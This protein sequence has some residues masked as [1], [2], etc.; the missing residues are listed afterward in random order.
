MT[1]SIIRFA[2]RFF[3]GLLILGL[4]VFA[5][6]ALALPVAGGALVELVPP[7]AVVADGSTSVKLV[8]LALDSDGS[9]LELLKAKV[10][11]N[12]GSVGKVKSAGPGRYAIEL[13]PPSVTEPQSLQLVLT[14][15]TPAKA[16]VTRTFHLGIT[17]PLPERWSL[18]ASPAVVSLGPG[19]TSTLSL[20]VE[21]AAD[22]AL[23]ELQLQ[24][25]AGSIANLTKLGGGRVTAL[26]TA[27]PVNYPHLDIITVVDRRD[28]D[29]LFTQLTL[30]LVGRAEFPVAATPGSSVLLTVGQR[31]FGP[32]VADAQGRAMVPL[33]VPPGSNQATVTTPQGSSQIDLG[34]PGFAQAAFLPPYAGVPGDPSLSVPLRLVVTTA[35]GEPDAEARP[36]VLAST[37]TLSEPVYEGNG[38]YRM[39]YSPPVV[40]VPTVVQLLANLPGGSEKH[41]PQAS[42]QVVPAVPDRLGLE[43]T[44]SSGGGGD[45]REARIEAVTAAG[46]GLPGQIISLGAVGASVRGQVSELSDGKYSGSVVPQDG[47]MEVWADPTCQPTGN[48]AHELLLLPSTDTLAFEGWTSTILTV[49]ALDELGHPVPGVLVTLS[50]ISG[51]GSLPAAVTTA[52]CGVARVGYSAGSTPGLAV[53]RASSGTL[54]AVTAILQGPGAVVQAISPG[55]SGSAHQL[56]LR[57][58]WAQRFPVLRTGS[59]PQAAVASAPVPAVVSTPE[60]ATAAVPEPPAPPVPVAVSAGPVAALAV[61]PQPTTVAPGATLTLNIGATDADGLGVPGERLDILVSAGAASAVTD[62]GDGRYRA[63]LQVPKRQADPLKITVSTADGEQFR[64]VKVPVGEEPVAV[65]AVP[66]P[67]PTPAAPPAQLAAEPAQPVPGFAGQAPTTTEPSERRESRERDTSA[68]ARRWLH[69]RGAGGVGSYGY[70][71]VVDA[72]PRTILAEGDPLPY[73]QSLVLEGADRELVPGGQ[74]SKQ[75]LPQVDLRARAWAPRLAYLG[76]DL[77]YRGHYLAVDTD[78]FAQYNEGPDLGY[79]DNFLTALVQARY[80]HD[81]GDTRL[82]LGAAGGTV[83]TAIPLPAYWSPDGGSAALWFF[84]WGFTSFYGGVRGGVETGFGLEL[85]A[86][87]G[88]GTERWTGLF[89]QEQSYELSC[90]VADHIT[91][92]LVVDFMA[93]HIVVPLED[94]EP[95]E[96]MVQVYDTRLGANLGMG[97]AF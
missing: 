1:R 66:E 10:T 68:T 22:V 52:G 30:P 34:I 15:R 18:E 48:P 82:W 28:P 19:A 73:E 71:Y 13:V 20:Q 4:P 32:V 36:E 76:A 83:T 11:T 55:A 93:R 6:P 84:P 78:A 40:T 75:I 87:A 61:E 57:E 94:I 25:L 92:E 8:I 45:A 39:D 24:A 64:F 95:Y 21:P 63:T 54:E 58:T 35:S 43:L 17:P 12:A 89:V 67:A 31:E 50:R 51:D 91:V 69:L 90:E 33:E 74:A 49:V 2:G 47:P 86:E 5:S 41:R 56:A 72:S 80:Y 97:V 29:R 38:I 42:F 88:F 65:A 46:L 81:L 26:Y 9:P 60:P 3:T 14:G 59:L 77:R 7:G 85:M 62:Q 23:E 79:W 96:P 70:E 16:P 53:L 37:G 27:P 44:P